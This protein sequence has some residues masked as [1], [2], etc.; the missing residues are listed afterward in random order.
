MGEGIVRPRNRPPLQ[1]ALRA[2]AVLLARPCPCWTP[3]R[4]GPPIVPRRQRVVTGRPCFDGRP[5]TG[6]YFWLG[7]TLA[8]VTDGAFAEEG[9]PELQSDAARRECT[10]GADSMTKRS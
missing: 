1:N 3:V 4:V 9:C 2:V 8:V 6:C 7:K 5:R 10:A